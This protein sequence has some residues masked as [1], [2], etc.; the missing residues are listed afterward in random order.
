M[1]QGLPVEGP[2]FRQSLEKHIDQW[3]E[4]KNAGKKEGNQ[5][6]YP[7]D[8]YW[9]VRCLGARAEPAAGWFGSVSGHFID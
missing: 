4:Q 7:F 3:K 5:N 9:F 1:V 2:S 8:P 6:Q